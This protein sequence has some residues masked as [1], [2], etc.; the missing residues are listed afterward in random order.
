MN[1]SPIKK[2]RNYLIAIGSPSCTAMSLSELDRVKTDIQ[3]IENLLNKQEYGYERVLA[4]QI[5]LSATSGKIKDALTSWFNSSN[6]NNSDHVIIYY[7]GH[8]GEEQEHNSHY[9]YTVE[10]NPQNL[11]N[12]TIKTSDLVRCLF[13]GKRNSPQNI[14]LILDVCYAGQGAKNVLGSV[15]NECRSAAEGKCFYVIASADSKTQAGDGDFVDAFEKVMSKSR[16]QILTVES[17]VVKTNEFLKEKS[18]K[19]ECYSLGISRE[20][21]FFIKPDFINQNESE[22]N[23]DNFKKVPTKSKSANVADI[24]YLLDYSAQEQVFKN[25]MKDCQERAFL[26]QAKEEKIQRW[27]VRRLAGCVPDFEQAKKFSI[28]IRSHP[29]RSDFNAFWEDFQQEIED[30]NVNRGTV[31]QKLAKLC[32][33]KSVIIAIYGLSY[34]DQAKINEFYVFWS[35]LVEKVQLVTQRSF[36]SRLVLLVAEKND[37]TVLNKLNLF[38]FIQP[39]A[40]NETQYSISLTPLDNILR[41]DIKNWLAQ[42]PVYSL[43]ERKEDEIQLIVAQDITNWE[44][45]PLDVL[46]EICQTVFQI[47]EGIAAIEPYWKLAG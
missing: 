47:Q 6:F 11:P 12:T 34:L 22:V 24:L 42:D 31:I 45:E 19:A 23:K 30:N 29:M 33:T 10:S 2:Q 44:E 36:R 8:G 20:T 41:N 5:Y 14:L 15:L 13:P 3:R 28:R 16:D 21:K 40:I 35:D 38:N 4:D 26:I 37:P 7:A 17:L 25:V 18:Q 32:A 46:E 43:L 1:V 39:P 27:L 9:L